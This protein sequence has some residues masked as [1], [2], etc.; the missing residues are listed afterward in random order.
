MTQRKT[1]VVIFLNVLRKKRK[2]T[3]DEVRSVGADFV[4]ALG[5]R[6]FPTVVNI[7]NGNVLFKKNS[8][9]K[10]AMA[11]FKSSVGRDYVE[12]RC[13]FT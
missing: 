4:Y 13:L 7:V 1:G 5:T 2:E 9:L 10:I 3:R 6:V 11:S 12:K 8:L